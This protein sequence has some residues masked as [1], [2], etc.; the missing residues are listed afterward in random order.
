[1]KKQLLLLFFGFFF[2]SAS[3]SAATIELFDWAFY[4]DGIPYEDVNENSMPTIGTLSDD[5]L[6]TLTWSTS[7][8]GDHTF[9]AFFDHEIDAD[10]NGYDNEYGMAYG[11][12]VEGQSWEIDEPGWD[13]DNPGDIY[14]NLLDGVLDNTNAVPQGSNDDMSWAM[15]WDFT[16]NQGQTADVS[17]ELGLTAPSAGFYLS[18]TDPNS[19]ETLYFSST[20][21][22]T[23]GSASAPVPEPGTVFLFSFGIMALLGMVKKRS[24]VI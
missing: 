17:L 13:E 1:M 18:H 8:L 2:L 3:A 5:G 23:G 10:T 21:S 11:S 14:Y 20:L 24:T 9:L 6:G 16:L 4:V 7:G 22:I 19:Q 15:G 12:P